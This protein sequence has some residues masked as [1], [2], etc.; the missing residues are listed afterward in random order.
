MTQARSV[1]A[2]FSPIQYYVTSTAGIGGSVNEINGSY[3]YD[4]NISIVATPSHGYTFLNW[5]QSGNGI[6][7]TLLPN[8]ILSVDNNQSVQANFTPIN[9][10]LNITSST[11]GSVTL[12][13][14]G[15]TQPYNSLV[16]L[17]ATPEN[18][19]YFTGW[20]GAGINDQNSS[21]TTITIT[22]DHSIQANFAENTDNK[23]LLHLKANP[24]FAAASF[25][26]SG[27]Y[28]ENDSVQISAHPNLGYTFSN[29]TGGSVVD[30]NSS[31][32]T[33]VVNQ[34][35]NLTAHFNLN[36]HTLNLS[37]NAGGLVNEVNSSYDYGSIVSLSA[38]PYSGYEFT[39]WD[40][41]ATFENQFSLLPL[42]P[43][44]PATQILPLF[45]TAKK[46]TL[47]VS[48]IGNGSTSGAGTY[49]HGENITFQ[50]KQDEGYTFDKWQGTESLIQNNSTLT[51]MIFQDLNLTATFTEST[52]QL[53]ETLEVV[54]FGSSWYSNDWFGYF[55]QSP[56][57]WCYHI[58]LGWIYPATP[59]RWQLVG[60]VCPIGMDMDGFNI[61]CH[62]TRMV[63]GRQ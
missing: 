53:N 28:D 23:L 36:Q 15:S 55:Y 34:D 47:A 14:T 13:P 29:W 46:Y 16:S 58:N 18:G 56:S 62:Q 39:S 8:T 24:D 1:T 57:G 43:L 51:I 33:I 52:P 7:N 49:S 20:Q 32:T 31:S 3:S 42:M 6:A 12:S 60:M 41:N 35:L 21:S 54:Q 48:V 25:N 9:Y 26:G 10:D 19:Y 59:N 40:G 45:F 4:A 63:R 37:A 22:G 44:L 5:T 38:T 17:I 27:L 61:I 11:G 50:H 30:E 2:N